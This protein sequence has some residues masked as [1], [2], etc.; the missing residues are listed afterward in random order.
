MKR[1]DITT[2]PTDSERKY[3][4]T[5]MKWKYSGEDTNYQNSPK[6]KEAA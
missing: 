3:L 6:K 2:D 1:G 4:K 5:Q